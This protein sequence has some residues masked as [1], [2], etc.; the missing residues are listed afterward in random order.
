[1][2]IADGKKC[3]KGGIA[4]LTNLGR[5]LRKI[6]IDHGEVLKNMADRFGVTASYLSAVE[7]GKRPIPEAWERIILSNYPLDKKQRA[8]LHKAVIESIQSINFDVSQA[9]YAGK[10]VAFAFARKVIDLP[11]EKLQEI[12]RILGGE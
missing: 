4:M 3:Q 9:S 6:R 11:E 12:K 2:T 10:E 5:L 1:M 8:E 7:N